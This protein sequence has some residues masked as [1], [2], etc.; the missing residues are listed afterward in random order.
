MRIFGPVPSRRLGRSLGLNNIPPKTCSYSCV[1]C[2]LGF[3]KKMQIERSEFYKP[4]EFIEEVK[5]KVEKIKN[6]NEKIDYLTFVSDGEPTL[7]I[8]LGKEIDMLK[9]LDIKIAVISNSSLIWRED[10]REELS[11]ADWVSLKVDSVIEENWRKIDC[12]SK[13][14]DLNKM[15]EGI[16]NFSQKYNGFFA[17]ETMLVESFNDTEYSLEKTA[18]FLGEINPDVSYIS[19]PVRPPARKDAK[20]PGE[21][22]INKA[23]QIFSNSLNNVEYLIGYEGNAFSFT[24]N[25][26]EDILSI[27]SVHPMREDAVEKFLK[28]V[29]TDWNVLHELVDKGKIR[30]VEYNDKKFYIRSF[31]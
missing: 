22:T 29:D 25:I 19:I 17:T 13:E 14:L 28:N 1:Y 27:T 9:S 12:P 3:T 8:N 6:S 2:Q 5:E 23:Y 11:K 20:K 31:K 7:D 24:G 21:E 30:E 26:E 18:Q 10:V 4:E 15:L 16:K